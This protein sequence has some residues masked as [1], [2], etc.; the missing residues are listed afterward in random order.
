M[1]FFTRAGG[2]RKEQSGVA[3]FL[4]EQAAGQLSIEE[5]EGQDTV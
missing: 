3:G 4:P 2:M 1:S 5:R